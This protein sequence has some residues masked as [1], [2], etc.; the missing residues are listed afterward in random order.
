ML[1][2]I[3]IIRVSEDFFKE[4]WLFGRGYIF[5]GGGISCLELF[6]GKGLIYRLLF[7]LIFRIVEL[8]KYLDFFRVFV[9]VDMVRGFFRKFNLY[10]L[11]V[12][13]IK[14]GKV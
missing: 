3:S 14:I 11:V 4:D 5:F 7:Y 10:F 8:K 6:I 9:G 13:G 2:V 1:V 12:G